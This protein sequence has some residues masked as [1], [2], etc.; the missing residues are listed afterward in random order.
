MRYIAIVVAIVL[1]LSGVIGDLV[2]EDIQEFLVRI[3][4]DRYRIFLYAAAVFI[5]VATVVSERIRSRYEPLNEAKQFALKAAR[6][7]AVREVR[8]PGRFEFFFRS[9]RTIEDV[10]RIFR[11][12]VLGT[13]PDAKKL[14]RRDREHAAK[15]AFRS[16]RI[17]VELLGNSGGPR[18]I[19]VTSPG[20]NEG[21]T[22]IASNL[23]LTC[24]DGGKNVVLV[25]SDL[26]RP[27]IHHLFR[28]SNYLGLSDVLMDQLEPQAVI[29]SFDNPHFNL[30][31]CGSR[32]DNPAELLGSALFLEVLSQLREQ[33][34]TVIFDGP[35][36]RFS[37]A[38]ILASRVESVL[39]V[40]RPGRTRK[41]VA[42]NIV[43]QLRRAQANLLG[44][45]LNRDPKSQAYT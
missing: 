19:F 3:L 5:L 42:R 40:I 14:A 12:P 26:R 33:F 38:L 16:L 34:D 1:F 32:V 13:I 39:L 18:F 31:T 37:E 4:G 7:A 6:P 29:T 35:G 10:E 11:V 25:D 44:V 21:K 28:V 23:A 8:D 22:T 43:N 41:S 45:V 30:I 9:I 36:L 15:E 27:S 24:A 17:N 2:A 20:D